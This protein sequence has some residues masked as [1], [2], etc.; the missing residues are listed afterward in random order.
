MVRSCAAALG[1][2]CFYSWRTDV[3]GTLVRLSELDRPAGI[4]AE[5]LRTVQNM[6]VLL[7][8]QFLV[9]SVVHRAVLRL[10]KT[11]VGD[12]VR[13][14]LDGRNRVMGAAGTA[15]R[16]PPSEYEEDRMYFS[17]IPFFSF[18]FS[19]DSN[20]NYPVVDL[21]CLL[22]SRI[23]TFRELLMIF[24]Y[25]KHW[26]HVDPLTPVL[27]EEE[28][29]DDDDND[30]HVRSAAQTTDDSHTSQRPPSPAL[31]Q[32][33]V[34]SAPVS[35]QTRKPEYEF[36]LFN[37]LL[38]FVHREGKIGDFARA[39]LLFLMDVA[40]S[41]GVPAHRLAENG[42]RG[43]S[44]ATTAS[45]SAATSDPVADAALAL[46]EYILDGDFCEVLGA[47][48]GAVY[49]LLPSKLEIRSETQ[50][51]AQGA[52]MAVGSLGPLTEEDK[53]KDAHAREKAYSEG[54]WYTSNPEF[55]SRL[56][57][58]VKLLEFLQDVLRRNVSESRDE[59]SVEPASF[60]GSAIVHSILDAVRRIFLENVLYP[61]I[62]ECSD[63]DGSAVAVM[64]YIDVI[65]RTVQDAQFAE[66][67][68]DFL[69]SEDDPESS[70]RRHRTKATPQL[71]SGPSVPPDSFVTRAAKI[72]RRKSSAMML[73][74][75]EAPDARRQSEYLTSMGR[76]TLKDLLLANMRSSSHATVTAALQ[77][78]QSLMQHHCHLTVDRL[79]IY[80][81]VSMEASLLDQSP[82]KQLSE[83][84]ETF[85]YPDPDVSSNIVRHS[86]A[87]MDARQAP[88]HHAEAT[89]VMH[90]RE[91]GLYLGLV[92]RIDPMHNK[93]TFSTG[94]EHYLKDAF[95]S[96]AGHACT[97]CLA[98]AYEEKQGSRLLDVNDPVLS[99]VLQSLRRFYLNTPQ[100]NIALTG[101][102]ATIASCP[103]RSI[104][105]WLVH[106]TYNVAPTVELEF[107]QITDDGDDRSFDH[108]INEGLRRHEI[109][110]PISR[111]EINLSRPVIFSILE[112][113]VA[114]LD[115]FRE[116]VDNFDKLLSE[117]R[118][119][120]V[121]SENLTDALSLTFDVSNNVT[122]ISHNNS[123][124][125]DADV[126]PAAVAHKL[127]PKSRSGW[128]S[129]LS[130][131]RSKSRPSSPAPPSQESTP[132]RSNTLEASPFGIHYKKTR[133][134]ILEPPVAPIPTSGSW[135]PAD[136]NRFNIDEEDVFGSAG[137]WDEER[138]LPTTSTRSE[139]EKSGEK[140][141]NLSQ[142]LDNVVILEESIKELTTIV[143]AR[144]SLGID[145]LKF[146]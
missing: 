115:R 122:K 108:A 8:E 114:S 33:T 69:V 119:G 94:Y 99:L 41:P 12:D 7:D 45:T 57:H 95:T 138:R 11:C 52:V 4:Q 63:T 1:N 87:A 77:L 133:D 92:A 75:M 46:A 68:L 113:L 104:Q 61:S 6:V 136:S 39:G 132:S 59:S 109:P 98:K 137:Q 26:Y 48:L 20:M 31:S 55:Q 142:I 86:T 127:K 80:T 117:R 93:G 73:L 47:G 139:T 120:L 82:S 123:R 85:V 112:G 101:V 131:K 107:N 21:L 22:C 78:M 72:K 96:V 141:V 103:E 51:N 56:D 29:D 38:R 130:P 54:V 23:R 90:E 36:L 58:F 43:D 13:E 10:L 2:G 3:L 24:F 97:S 70:R 66:A 40:M 65:F 145:T 135:A 84:E 144:R 35:S 15:T 134:I 88:R 116:L 111:A 27:E 118:Q 102:L 106:D 126:P 83:D 14:Q 19:H 146:F 125:S 60:V 74:E 143:H 49:S 110:A 81:S 62:L 71:E 140:S 17:L 30:E 50:E 18:S 129:F 105:G 121:F 79:F 67:L 5:V 9:H 16:T 32:E 28:D 124:S 100:M 128:A 25:D 37:Y 76:F 53:D 91:L 44:S 64:S 34:T 42:N 89:S